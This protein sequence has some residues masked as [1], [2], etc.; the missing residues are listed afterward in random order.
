MIAGAGDTTANW[1]TTATN[2]FNGNFVPKT[3]TTAVS[4][5]FVDN[6]DR[7]YAGTATA[8]VH[9]TFM[10]VIGINSIH[11]SAAATTAVAAVQS[12]GKAK[13]IT[14]LNLT[15]QKGLGMS[16]SAAVNA[17]NCIVTV[18]SNHASDA[19]DLSGSTTITSADNCFVGKLK[20][21]SLSAGS[22]SPMQL[23]RP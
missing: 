4:T 21:Y 7:T 6:G 17:P 3:D 14:A 13:C 5:S 19:V 8:S 11:I 16:G 23:A 10:G 2:T 9:T 20:S 1:K 12:P 22:P 15:A 18:I